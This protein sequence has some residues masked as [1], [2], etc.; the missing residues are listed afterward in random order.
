VTL[1]G[2][3]IVFTRL[4]FAPCIKGI[5]HMGASKLGAPFTI[6]PFGHSN[7][8]SYARHCAIW[9]MWMH[10]TQCQLLGS[11][12]FALARLSCYFRP[13]QNVIIPSCVLMLQQWRSSG[14][15]DSNSNGI[16]SSGLQCHVC[17]YQFG[18]ASD[19]RRHARL[20]HGIQD[21]LLINPQSTAT[22][23]AHS[24]TSHCHERLSSATWLLLRSACSY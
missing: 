11:F 7:S 1:S 2:L 21:S 23:P 3:N 19:L 13:W 10:R 12:P 18:N 24:A 15:D 8:S 16:G 4:N 17:Q 9:H 22:L 5:L 20:R 6:L 14:N